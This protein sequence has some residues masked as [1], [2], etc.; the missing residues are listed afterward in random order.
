MASDADEHGHDPP[1]KRARLGCLQFKCPL[2]AAVY[3]SKGRKQALEDVAVYNVAL[4]VDGLA[5]WH[6][7][8]DGHGGAQ[9]AALAAT[10][11]PAL[12]AEGIRDI[13]ASGIEASIAIKDAIKAAFTTC[14]RE[15]LPLVDDGCCVIGMLVDRR[16]TP[17]R[18]YVANLGDSRAFACVEPAAATADAAAGTSTKTLATAP[19]C[20]APTVRAIA[21]SKD[22]V[23]TDPKERRR[24]EVA[25]GVIEHGRVCGMLE[26]TRSLGDRLVKQRLR[27]GESAKGEGIS[28]VPDVTSFAVGLE[29]RFVLMASDGFWKAWTSSEAIEVLHARLCAMDRR[30]EV[31]ATLLD[32]PTAASALTR[33]AHA[34]LIKE[35]EGATEEGCLKEMVHEAVHMRHAKDNV[36]AL[37]V[38]MPPAP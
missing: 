2:R 5:T 9:C 18:A 7:V 29:Q 27:K 19:S 1:P 22:H 32:E 28:A 4:D 36:T 16:C 35:R 20:A 8:I 25:G 21:L 3:Y 10:R 31:L 11:L 34:A 13:E 6:A 38:R 37:L 26:V 14:E 12:I 15:V 30:R 33:E 17:A 24:I 23:A